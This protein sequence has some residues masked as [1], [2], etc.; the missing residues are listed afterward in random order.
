[1]VAGVQIR[2][3]N[4]PSDEAKVMSSNGS[5]NL[6]AAAFPPVSWK[7]SM[8]PDPDCCDAAIPWPLQDSRPG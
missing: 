8:N 1:M 2:V 3:E 4:Q 6:P 7:L 5:T